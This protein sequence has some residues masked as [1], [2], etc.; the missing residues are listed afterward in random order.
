MPEFFRSDRVGDHLKRELAIL[1]Q[2]EM[3][4]PRVERININ[5]VEVRRDL[6]AARVF[7]T[8]VGEDS[9]QEGKKTEAVL[10]KASGFLRSK[11][12]STSNMRTT[13]K[14]IFCYD[15]SVIAGDELSRLI[16]TAVS[17]DEKKR[18]D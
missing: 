11:L 3:N 14:L 1:I 9:E 13:P 10:E 17:G 5:D 2:S 16:E 4:D 12:A 18:G 8:L 15:K 7:F 6:S